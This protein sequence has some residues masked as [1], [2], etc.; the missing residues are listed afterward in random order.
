MTET[1]ASIED[2]KRALIDISELLERAVQE[3][4]S[5]ASNDVRSDL[6]RRSALRVMQTADAIGLLSTGHFSEEIRCLNRSLA[7]TVINAAYLQRASSSEVEH[8][9][10]SDSQSMAKTAL[11]AN[12]VVSRLIKLDPEEQVE[13]RRLSAQ[14]TQDPWDGKSLMQRARAVDSEQAFGH[15]MET[16]FLIVYEASHYYV[17]NTFTPIMKSS[18]WDRGRSTMSLEARNEDV[19]GSLLPSIWCVFSLAMYVC[20]QF[21]LT[22]T[23]ELADFNER[24]GK[25]AS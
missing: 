14:P 17:H 7:E 9:T 24:L 12:S 1:N 18:E 15:H 22:A 23:S 25:L 13:M 21:N 10:K 5:S 2:Y 11:R 20:E 19:V 6:L 8:Y 4:V 16:L 3:F